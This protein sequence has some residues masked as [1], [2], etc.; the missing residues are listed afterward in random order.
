M[1]L[2]ENVTNKVYYIYANNQSELDIWIKAIQV[3]LFKNIRQITIIGC[4]FQK[5]YRTKQY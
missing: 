4:I 1:E 2:I 3:L 5:R